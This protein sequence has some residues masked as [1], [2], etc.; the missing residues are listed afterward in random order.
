MVFE[1]T[2]LC[3]KSQEIIDKFMRKRK[4]IHKTDIAASDSLN[5]LVLSEE[6]KEDRLS[7]IIDL[8]RLEHLNK[9]EQEN[10]IKLIANSQ[11]RFHILGEK[12]TAT[13]VLQHQ[14]TTTDDHPINTRQYRFP[15]VHKE[16][17]N[18]Q[19]EDLLQ[20]GIVKP[21]QS[22]YN[23]PIWIVPKKDDSK[24][25]KR[26]RMVL[27]FRAL[28]EKTIGDAYPLPNIVDILDQLGGA[29]SHLL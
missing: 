13:H 3:K 17:I 22:P 8:L 12:L 18:K 29:M 25:N 27:N 4:S 24:G 9:E 16:E 6:T 19:V 7:K 28:N 26:W 5:C 23:T 21:S 14:I 20:E 10:I 15:Q 1:H 11:D 2:S